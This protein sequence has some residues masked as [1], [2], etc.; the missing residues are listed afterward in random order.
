MTVAPHFRVLMSLGELHCQTG[1]TITATEP[2]LEALALARDCH[3]TY[4][5]AMATLYLAYVQV[6]GG[7]IVFTFETIPDNLNMLCYIGKI[8]KRPTSNKNHC[9]QAEVAQISHL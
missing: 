5:V 6:G 9:S 3:M 7:L 8:K 2:L 4:L 1:N